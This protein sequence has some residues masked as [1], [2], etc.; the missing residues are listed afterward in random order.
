MS[1]HIYECKNVVADGG[2]NIKRLMNKIFT[3]DIAFF[4][5]KLISLRYDYSY[6]AF[7]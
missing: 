7:L 2:A 3:K 5:E 6:R 1:N 4:E